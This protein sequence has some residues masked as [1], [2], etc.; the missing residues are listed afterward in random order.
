MPRRRL[1]RAHSFSQRQVIGR[2]FRRDEGKNGRKSH[3]QSFSLHPILDLTGSGPHSFNGGKGETARTRATGEPRT[4]LDEAEAEA[5]DLVGKAKTPILLVAE[6]LRGGEVTDYAAALLTG[7]AECGFEARMVAAGLPPDGRNRQLAAAA[8]R[9][10]VV[11]GI[12]WGTFNLFSFLRMTRWARRFSPVLIHGLSAFVA[13]TCRGLAR[14][15]KVPWLLTVHHYQRRGALHADRNC[16]GFVALSDALRTNLVNTSAAPKE[17]VSVLPLGISMPEKRKTDT[18]AA[19]VPGLPRLPLVVSCGALTERKDY[20]TLLRAAR[21]VLDQC[22]GEGHFLIAGEGPKERALRRLRA[23]LGLARHVTFCLEDSFPEEVWASLDVYVQT[24]HA[25]AFNIEVARASAYGAP[26]V[27]AASGGLISQVKDGKTGY[28]VPP[29]DVD[30]LAEK[31]ILL[32]DDADLRHRLG[33]AGREFAAKEYSLAA[34][35]D[36]TAKLYRKL[37]EPAEK[38]SLAAR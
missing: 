33:E 37:L 19:A 12:S 27:A 34:M 1:S 30:A 8:N 31:L 15:L 5:E 10:A 4:E 25:D 7:L 13:P 6:P 2:R 26:V 36:R 18:P 24:S 14:S 28:L 17:L 38:D 21:K 20:S 3:R 32:L 29:G 11:P 22:A 16:G 23:E 35:L 9:I